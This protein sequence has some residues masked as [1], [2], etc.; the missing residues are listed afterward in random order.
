[1]NNA[2]TAALAD[3]ST[4]A[5]APPYLLPTVAL[6]LDF[7]G[8]LAELAMRPEA[9]Q[10]PTRLPALLT[11]LYSRH[12]GAL[13]IVTGR[14]LMHVDTLLAPVRLPGAGV[15]GAELR[16]RPNDAAVVRDVPG[17]ASVAQA[18]RELYEGDER[19]QI[20]N[21]GGAVALYFRL[22]PELGVECVDTM[23]RLAASRG[24]E[25]LTGNQVVEAHAAGIDKGSA[26]REL[27]QH[28]PFA[29]RVPVFVGDDRT[30]EYAF[31]AAQE[32]GGYGVKVGPGST[33]ALYRLESV[34]A[35]HA[36]L[37]ASF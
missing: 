2:T 5:S 18:L 15:H 8:T 35:V 37:R 9:V 26:L 36:W 34:P 32:L 11:R 28:A 29:G 6:Y 7:D 1:M 4:T 25:V 20:E 33:R 23:R 22:A 19:L 27:S 14:R 3:F 16:L 24:L 30:D 13:A 31:D 17:I 10:V 12:G 21:K